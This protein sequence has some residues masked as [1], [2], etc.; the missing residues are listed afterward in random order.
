MIK[1]RP[2]NSLHDQLSKVL[3]LVERAQGTI[4][5]LPVRR[6]RHA[7]VGRKDA[8]PIATQASDLA[9]GARGVR[10]RRVGDLR[11]ELVDRYIDLVEIETL[12]RYEAERARDRERRRR[13][14]GRERDGGRLELA[15]VV[16]VRALRET[17]PDGTL[18]RHR[19]LSSMPSE[20]RTVLQAGA[21]EREGDW[22]LVVVPRLCRPASRGRRPRLAGRS[23]YRGT[24]RSAARLLGPSRWQPYARQDAQHQ[25]QQGRRGGASERR[26]AA[27]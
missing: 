7:K 11:S 5:T 25:Q 10:A 23:G 15:A 21:S 27:D 18:V 13:V 20:Q 26:A 6:A 19:V 12:G 22:A 14:Q 3:G 2:R 8:T 17:L 1:R 9:R 16:G 24:P 4:E